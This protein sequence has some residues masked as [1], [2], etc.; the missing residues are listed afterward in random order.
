MPRGPSATF[1]VEVILGVR[2]S[3]V[4]VPVDFLLSALTLFG[5]AVWHHRML[6]V[7][8][9]G[10]AVITRHQLPWAGLKTGPG[11]AGLKAQATHESVT[12]ANQFGLLLGS[13]LLGDHF[14]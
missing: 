13:A 11:V 10:A 9:T 14:E 7:A 3:A 1:R 8:L 2:A 5:A 4:G 12:L 6:E